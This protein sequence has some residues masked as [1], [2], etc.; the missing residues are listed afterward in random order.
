[1]NSPF[2][3]IASEAP[4][5]LPTPRTSKPEE[6]VKRSPL[7]G[8]LSIVEAFYHRILQEIAYFLHYFDDIIRIPPIRALQATQGNGAAEDGSPEPGSWAAWS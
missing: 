3:L 6:D 4:P 1:M 7:A 8:R 2:I 5:T